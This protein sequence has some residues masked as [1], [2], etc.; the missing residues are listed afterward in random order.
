MNTQPSLT[1]EYNKEFDTKDK[2][3]ANQNPS[4]LIKEEFIFKCHNFFKIK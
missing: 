1:G 3:Y 4:S 2:K